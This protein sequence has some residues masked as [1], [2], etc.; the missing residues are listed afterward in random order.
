MNRAYFVA[1]APVVLHCPTTRDRHSLSSAGPPTVCRTDRRGELA[2]VRQSL[3]AAVAV[4]LLAPV[5]APARAMSIDHYGD[6]PV[7]QQLGA[8]L[9]KQ[10]TSGELPPRHADPKQET[11]TQRHGT[12]GGTVD[13]AADPAQAEGRV[14]TVPGRGIYVVPSDERPKTWPVLIG[15]AGSITIAWSRP[16]GLHDRQRERAH[17]QKRNHRRNRAPHS[18]P[19]PASCGA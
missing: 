9:H 14:E 19:A 2:P 5:V 16:P 11:L 18:Q 15:A 12:S 3:A 4:S 7:Y 13:R 1:T 8:I 10:I 6:V 17:P